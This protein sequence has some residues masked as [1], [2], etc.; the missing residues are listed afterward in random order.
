MTSVGIPSRELEWKVWLL[1][2]LT[3]APLLAL[4]RLIRRGNIGRNHLRE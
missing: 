4:A 1:G 3:V 2:L